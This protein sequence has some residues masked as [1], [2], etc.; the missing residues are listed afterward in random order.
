MQ[1]GPLTVGPGA[2][3]QPPE[4]C[5]FVLNNH[6]DLGIPFPPTAPML[7]DLGL[8]LN[9]TVAEAFLEAVGGRFAAYG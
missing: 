5:A 7:G 6:T 4:F 9:A 1:G 8:K 3:P 2:F